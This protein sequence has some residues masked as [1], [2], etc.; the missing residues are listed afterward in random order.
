MHC[1]RVDAFRHRA[2]AIFGDGSA[3][4]QRL[5]GLTLTLVWGAHHRCHARVRSGSERGTRDKGHPV[6]VVADIERRARG[7]ESGLGEL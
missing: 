6:L 3:E 7:G 4:R 5:P 1:S 2:A